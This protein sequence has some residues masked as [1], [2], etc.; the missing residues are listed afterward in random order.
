MPHDAV[1]RDASQDAASD[2]HTSQQHKAIKPLPTGC[3]AQA[4][5]SAATSEVVQ[6]TWEGSAVEENFR[7]LSYPRVR[8]NAP[9]DPGG[10][11][12][13]KVS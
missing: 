4:A 10:P 9:A 13:S 6:G 5:V 12:D 8:S 2:Y 11:G 1:T 7:P 3:F